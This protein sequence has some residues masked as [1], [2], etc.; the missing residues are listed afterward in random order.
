MNKKLLIFSA[1]LAAANVA[2]A[3]L[4]IWQND[5]ESPNTFFDPAPNPVDMH[6]GRDDAW[7]GAGTAS[8]FDLGSSNVLQLL[9]G[10]GSQTRGLVRAFAAVNHP[11]VI[12]TTGDVS[13]Y[14]QFTFDLVSMFNS[15]ELNL[16]FLDGTRDADGSNPET[17]TYGI[18]LLSAA[19]AELTHTSIGTGGVTNLID[20]TF[21]KADEGTGLTVTFD[22]DG[23]GDLVMVWDSAND[24]SANSGTLFTR[25]D[26]MSLVLVP[27]PSIYALLAGF[28]TLG[29]VLVR[30]RLR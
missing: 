29:L 28:A 20:V 19:G 22:W 7:L 21:V 27:E 12:D 2:T 8:I 18:D 25:T 11:G 5:F 24:D 1:A 17:N 30:R 4:T 13:K 9:S 3:Q 26:N 10:G 6:N 14:Y 23:T 16:Q 15:A